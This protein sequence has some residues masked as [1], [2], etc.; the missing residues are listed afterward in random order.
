[1]TGLTALLQ[2]ASISSS[3]KN[4]IAAKRYVLNCYCCWVGKSH[5]RMLFTAVVNQ[6]AP[7][8]AWPPRRDERREIYPFSFAS[9]SRDLF[10]H[11]FIRRARLHQSHSGTSRRGPRDSRI[12]IEAVSNPRI[13]PRPELEIG[14]RVATESRYATL[15]P[16]TRHIFTK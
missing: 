13:S 16:A 1:V 15:A 3:S 6:T 2:E 12:E 5:S 14:F 4:D 11:V 9:P 8:H 10:V 7:K